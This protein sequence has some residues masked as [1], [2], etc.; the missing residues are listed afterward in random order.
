M[1]S[2]TNSCQ[3]LMHEGSKNLCSFHHK[4]I[5]KSKVNYLWLSFCVNSCLN[6]W[7]RLRIKYYMDEKMNQNGSKGLDYLLLWIS[8]QLFSL[9]FIS[10]VFLSLWI[11]LGVITW[12]LFPHVTE[13]IYSV[14]T[15]V[16]TDLTHREEESLMLQSLVLSLLTT[17]DT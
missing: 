6:Y 8:L 5:R 12:L 14:V 3:F 10:L 1:S 17:G 2:N 16:E 4:N 7:I 11:S 9:V 15:S 13:I